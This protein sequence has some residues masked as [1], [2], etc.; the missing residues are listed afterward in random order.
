MEDWD[1]D[2]EPHE[3][4]YVR[5]ARHMTGRIEGG[6]W[7]PGRRLPAELE[8]A[9]EY[10]V[11]YHTIRRA[12]AI[13]RL[14]RMVASVHGRGTFVLPKDQWLPEEEQDDSKEE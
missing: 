1:P 6:E 11:A 13:L 12:V 5:V 8:L 9:E 14:R 4:K 7:R 10:R 2:A 3:F